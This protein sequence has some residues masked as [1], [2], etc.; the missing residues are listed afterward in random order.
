MSLNTS[1][2]GALRIGE[3][4]R[5]PRHK[6]PS[7]IYAQ[8]GS[9]TGGIVLNLGIDGVA[10]HVAQ[11]VTSEINS[12]INIRLRGSGLDAELTGQLVWLG[13]TQKEVGVRFQDV[14][15]K[16]QKAIG[17]WIGREAQLFESTGL[18]NRAWPKPMSAIPGVP[19]YSDPRFS[20][21]PLPARSTAPAGLSAQ[22]GASAIPAARPSNSPAR[23]DPVR[24]KSSAAAPITMGPGVSERETLLKKLSAPISARPTGAPASSTK[25]RAT[26]SP[27]GQSLFEP[28]PIERPFQFPGSYPSGSGASAKAKPSAGQQRSQT[29]ANTSGKIGPRKSRVTQTAPPIDIAQLWESF[30]KSF[31]S[32]WLPRRILAAWAQGGRPRKLLLASS[33]AAGVWILGLI[34]LLALTHGDRSAEAVAA[35]TISNTS[36]QSISSSVPGAPPL[37]AVPRKHR[38][39]SFMWTDIGNALLGRKPVVRTDID[40]DEVGVQVW[41]SQPTGFYY[42][43]DTPYFRNVTPGTFMTQ[44]DALQTGYHPKLGQFCE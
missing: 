3:R 23:L 35:A 12:T 6:A 38:R 31:L 11:K 39:K 8:L 33:A 9:N 43:T 18:E 1:S 4:R 44:S 29:S 36:S 21:S 16:V 5:N 30:A 13:A 7:I 22:S 17:D 20:Q 2:Q 25:N 24:T 37:P 26:Q 42:C 14:S 28:I 19:S 34:F 40:E 27:G 41:A 10:C 32:N 15:L